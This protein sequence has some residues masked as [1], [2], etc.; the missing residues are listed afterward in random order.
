[1]SIFLFAQRTM[2][3]INHEDPIREDKPLINLAKQ[4]L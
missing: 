3:K 4:A 2:P 1:M